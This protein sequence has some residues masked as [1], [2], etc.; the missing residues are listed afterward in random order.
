MPGSPPRL[1]SR[2]LGSTPPTPAAVVALAERERI[3][4]VVV[5]PEAPLVAGVGDALAAA[6]VRCFGPGAGAARLEGSK[7]F[8]KEVMV[9]AGVPTAAYTVVTDVDA[10]MAAIP[11]YPW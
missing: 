4:L 11:G 2:T 6:G 8:C 5:G 3:D 7:A 1:R 10:G 9:A